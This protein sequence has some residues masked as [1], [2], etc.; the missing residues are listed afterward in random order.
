MLRKGRANSVEPKRWRRVEELFY[1]AL[2]RDPQTASEFLRRACGNDTELLREVQSLVD[3]SQH[4]LDFAYRAV[5][6]VARE[7]SVGLPSTGERVGAY[8]LQKKLG[9]GGMGAVYLAIRANGKDKQQVAIKLMQP[10]IRL[11]QRMLQRFTTERKILANLRHP[12]IARLLDAGITDD[13]FPYLIMEYVDGMPIDDYCR[14]TGL[15]TNDRLK[16][17]LIVCAAVE[18][19][20]ENMVVHRDIKPA[21]I[22]VT[23]EGVPKLLDFGIAKLLDPI[24]KEQTVTRL[25]Q[26]MMTLEYASPEQV[27]GGKITAAADVYALGVLLYVLLAGRHPFRLKG[28]NPFEIG[29]I[30]CEQQAEAPSRTIDL[31]AGRGPADAIRRL[32]G[33]L[34]HIVLTAIHK[35]PSSRYASVDALSRD[36]SA[37]LNGY[38]LQTRTYTPSYHA[39]MFVRRHKAPS[40]VVVLLMIIALVAFVIG[41]AMNTSPASQKGDVSKV[42]GQAGKAAPSLHWDH[43]EE[44]VLQSAAGFTIHATEE[45]SQHGRFV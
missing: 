15:L 39:W 2:E 30:I 12:N 9:E 26:R 35:R 32:Q 8:M 21:N 28:K 27:D 23:R 37:Y 36:V 31:A 6:N 17:F 1:A 16:L 13:D 3:S 24:V 40:I 20:H 14:E 44:A 45:F 10:W 5:L 11:S 4:S 19:A 18:H 7:Q 29:Q 33:D 38:P 25:S 22:L 42:S 41:I 43:R 34:D